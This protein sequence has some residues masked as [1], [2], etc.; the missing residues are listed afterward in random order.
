MTYLFTSTIALLTSAFV[1]LG[2][3][4]TEKNL[5]GENTFL[6]INSEIPS[7][8]YS[9]GNSILFRKLCYAKLQKKDYKSALKDCTKSIEMDPSSFYPIYLRG[10]AK[11]ALNDLQGAIED[12]KRSIDL[13]PEYQY[14]YVS[15]GDVKVKL[16]D[17]EG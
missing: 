4:G 10:E 6:D 12:Y 3:L 14:A 9:D 2:P 1:S 7:L 16:N 13:Y 15:I 17:L 11:S 8:N 5:A